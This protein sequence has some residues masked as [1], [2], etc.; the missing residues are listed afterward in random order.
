VAQPN[1]FWFWINYFKKH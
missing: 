1:T